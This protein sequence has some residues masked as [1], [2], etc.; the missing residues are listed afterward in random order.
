[1]NR[2]ILSSGDSINTG[3]SSITMGRVNTDQIK[4]IEEQQRT[5]I[6]QFIDVI[7]PTS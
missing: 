6:E 3:V 2:K 5:I 1:M 4:F 7:T